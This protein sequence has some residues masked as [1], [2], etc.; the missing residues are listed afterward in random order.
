MLRMIRRSF[1]MSKKR[2]LQRP[3]VAD[4]RELEAAS[5]QLVR[6]AIADITRHAVLRQIVVCAAGSQPLAASPQAM[7]ATFDPADVRL[8]RLSYAAAA[9]LV[10]VNKNQSQ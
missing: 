5:E 9:G 4:E 2:K 1:D 7:K 3:G 6:Q 10:Y 8:K